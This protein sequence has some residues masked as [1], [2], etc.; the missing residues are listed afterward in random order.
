MKDVV[1]IGGGA[2]GLVASIFAAM[3]GNKVTI[4]EKNNK[5]GK[6][7]LI[8]GN[9]RCNYFNNDMDINH[10]H[11]DNT[12]QLKKIITEE[13]N[14][15]ILNFI[16]SLGIV[17]KIKNG[18]YYP[19][20]NQATSVLNALVNK[21]KSLGVE[22]INDY[23]VLHI[24][25]ENHFIINDN[26]KAKNLI[27]ASGGKAYAKTGSDGSSYI[28]A[29]SL[30]HKINKPLPSL[31]K[32]TGNVPKKWAGIRSDVIVSL[33]EN[34]KFIKSEAGEIQLTDYGIS[35]ICVFNISHFV[36]KG[37]SENK[38][39]E[40]FINFAP[41]LKTDLIT[42]LSA[43]KD[44]TISQI[45]E[46]FLNYK[47]VNIILE[48]SHISKDSYFINLNN[49]EKNKLNN[50]VTSFPVL[51]TGTKSFDEAQVTTGGVS[52]KEIDENMQSKIIPNLY[53]IGEAVDV[54]GDCGGYNIGFAF[55]SGM[56]AGK[57]IKG[58]KNA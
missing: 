51:I 36:S 56:I 42:Y 15:K 13:N 45:L 30:S 34:D 33:Y 24:K 37:L 21:A 52:F 10:Y 41:F 12:E 57:S 8:T 29:S 25:K 23:N 3:N 26:I 16:D 35:G 18:Y 49:E 2:S 47:L 50:L 46:G 40:V 38:K 28:L 20:S 9:G 31:V 5:C 22:I 54:D 58:D 4:L 7:L 27:I 11:T 39:E 53:I 48:K 6:K 32:L 14:K 44:L 1:I 43:K 17:H 55:I 19:Y